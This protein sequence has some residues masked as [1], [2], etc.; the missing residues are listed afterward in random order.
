MNCLEKV[1]HKI[2]LINIHCKKIILYFRKRPVYIVLSFIVS[3][4]IVFHDIYKEY[5]NP[6]PSPINSEE[7]DEKVEKIIKNLFDHTKFLQRAVQATEDQLK[8]IPSYEREAAVR[9]LKKGDNSL[10]LKEILKN[11][12]KHLENIQL[13]SELLNNEKMLAGQ[14]YA[15]AGKVALLNSIGDALKF[16]LLS[17]DIWPHNPDLWAEIAELAQYTL[18]WDLYIKANEQLLA[19]AIADTFVQS[20]NLP[21]QE[22]WNE[23]EKSNE[24]P[25]PLKT[26]NFF[27]EIQNKNIKSLKETN[28]N[29]NEN[30]LLI[31]APISIDL[32]YTYFYEYGDL[33][34]AKLYLNWAIKQVYPVTFSTFIT[35][36]ELHFYLDL[37]LLVCYDMRSSIRQINGDYQSEAEDKKR[38]RILAKRASQWG[39]IYKNQGIDNEL[40]LMLFDFL[41][42]FLQSKSKPNN[43]IHN[44]NNYYLLINILN[45]LQESVTAELPLRKDKKVMVDQ[46]S[47]KNLID[48]LTLQLASIQFEL[49]SSD[50]L[51]LAKEVSHRGVNLEQDIEKLSK[52]IVNIENILD[53][54][55]S[56]LAL[57]EDLI[58]YKRK[59]IF[60]LFV[61]E[62]STN[63]LLWQ[64]DKENDGKIEKYLPKGIDSK[65]VEINYQ[66]IEIYRYLIEMRPDWPRI[67]FEYAQDLMELPITNPRPKWAQRKAIEIL[68]SLDDEGIKFPALSETLH[69]AIQQNEELK[70]IPEVS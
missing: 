21:I 22:R 49:E 61:H 23:F 65:E 56:V 13:S 11:A 46:L 57:Y 47:S 1:K 10:A 28:K 25:E 64:N 38:V 14:S 48:K 35:T 16:Y 20:E 15:D 58:D 51:Y 29:Q 55:P 43:K 41:Q 30:S 5:I 68:R 9:K 3:G 4:G 17:I 63:K 18:Q 27:S 36:P 44:M 8:E 45:T 52:I 12:E 37:F 62:L 33:H 32:A 50:L 54:D 59:Y 42:S 53:K 40:L 19:G 70:R 26:Y 2:Y 39:E 24:I 6:P 66:V 69:D 31:A 60:T 7:L 34:T 67:K